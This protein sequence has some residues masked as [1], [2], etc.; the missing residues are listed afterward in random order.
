MARQNINKGT[1][2]NDGTGDT[3][4]AAAT[5]INGNFVELYT[6]LGGDSAQI[7]QKVSLSDSGVNYAGLSHNTVLGFIEGSARTVINLPGL[8]GTLIT[9]AATQTITNKTLTSPVL[10]TP[11][12]NDTSANHQYVVAVSELTADR[13]ITLPLLSTNDTFVFAN[14][15]QTLTNKTFTSPTLTT[16]KIATAVNDTNNAEI[17][18]LAPTS[19][20]VNEIQISNA[21]T[22]GVPQIAGTGNDTNVGLGL[23]GTG[24]GLVHIQT[25][26]RFKPENI[27]N[28]G[29]IS[30]SRALTVFEKGGPIIAT[31]ANGT[32]IGERKILANIG[33]GDVTI[34]PATFK[35]G[36]SLTLR[37]GALVNCIWIDSTQ[38]W[39]IESPKIY[40]SSDAAALFFVTA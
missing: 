12:I 28:N 23:S 2:A 15:A 20:A 33:S 13:N 25:G 16:P 37:D 3:L 5:K 35:N 6:L 39:M 40:P 36:T 22:N 31:L 4:R 17:I 9:D 26:I 14:H 19:S 29:A 24:N 11:Q 10:T 32:F 38:G 1:S 21:A 30:P 27:N 8:G 18:K 7:T 34:T